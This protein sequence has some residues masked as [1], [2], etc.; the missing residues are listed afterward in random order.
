[1][2]LWSTHLVRRT[3]EVKIESQSRISWKSKSLPWLSCYL[4]EF[5]HQVVQSSESIASATMYNF[6]LVGL[7]FFF[8]F[9]SSLSFCHPFN[10][11]NC[12]SVQLHCLS[13]QLLQMTI[14][15]STRSRPPTFLFP[16][17]VFCCQTCDF[18]RF[19]FVMSEK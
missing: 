11:T 13:I 17:S 16:L 1:M 10:Q 9:L 18:F 5:I 8:F 6:C 14:R 3:N 7:F 4:L 2:M 12:I 19:I 15:T